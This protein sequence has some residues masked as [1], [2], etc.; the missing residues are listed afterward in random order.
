MPFKIHKI[1]SFSRKKKQLK[2]SVP[3]LPKI[4]RPLTRNT[5]ISLFGLVILQWLNPPMPEPTLFVVS[6][7]VCGSLCFSLFSDTVLRVLSSFVIILLRK[8]EL[9]AL[10][11]VFLLLCVCLCVLMSVPLGT[12]GWCVICDCRI[13]FSNSLTFHAWKKSDYD[14]VFLLFFLMRGGRI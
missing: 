3:T 4:F 14:Y 1:T 13:S 12:M 6:P 7:L 10:L 5:L 2:K 11:I 9:V 8:R